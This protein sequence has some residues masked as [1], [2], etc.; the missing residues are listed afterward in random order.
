[1]KLRR[2]HNNKGY[3]QIR[4]GS[5]RKFIE[6]LARSLGVPVRGS[7]NTGPVA[8]REKPVRA[9]QQA[10]LPTRQVG[11]A[12]LHPREAGLITQHTQAVRL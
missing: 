9:N 3:R 7:A 10:G 1:M 5:T 12:Y 2:H 4:N 6:R 11:R 8:G